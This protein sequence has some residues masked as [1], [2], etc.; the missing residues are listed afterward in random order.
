M[1]IYTGLH[2]LSISFYHHLQFPLF[3][4]AQIWIGIW[5]LWYL[6]QTWNLLRRI[7]GWINILSL[8][9]RLMSSWSFERVVQIDIS[10]IL[11]EKRK[12]WTLL[13]IITC[14]LA[15]A[16]WIRMTPGSWILRVSLRSPNANTLVLF[17]ATLVPPNIPPLRALSSMPIRS[18]FSADTV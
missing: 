1:Q 11:Y 13:F 16:T 3:L 9:Y 12:E 7:H 4:W 17:K 15:S 18:D 8:H 10:N 14:S 5:F 2:W 6:L